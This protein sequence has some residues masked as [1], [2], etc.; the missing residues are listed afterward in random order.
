MKPPSLSVS[1]AAHRLFV[2][3]AV[4]VTGL[5][6]FTTG[7]SSPAVAAPAAWVETT[8]QEEP[9]LRS[10]SHG[11][12]AIVSLD[13]GRLIHFGPA[14]SGENLLFAPAAKDHPDGWGGHRVWLGPQSTWSGGW[15]PP[16]AW[17][18]SAAET[19]ELR[20]DGSLVI[21]PPPAGDG[22]PRF[23][24]TYRWQGARLICGVEVKA[25]GERDYQIIQ[26]VQM[27]DTTRVRATLR[28]EPEWPE[29]YVGLP[30]FGRRAMERLPQP[31]PHASMEGRVMHLRHLGVAE[32]LGLRPKA[33]YGIDLKNTVRVDRGTEAGDV[34]DWPDAG[35]LTHVYL[36]GREPFVELEQLSPLWRAGT[37]ATFELTLEPAP[38]N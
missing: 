23:L 19:T 9:A 28:P 14:D 29:G 33:L 17:E 13:R 3:A 32:K 21:V 4:T 22:W 30:R 20:P 10:T 12:T 38:Q 2:L 25:R 11:W 8:W 5:L 24:R 31:P 1:A 34:L 16:A 36:G 26:I 18:R 15:P 37:A 27:P 35:F 6:L 7:L